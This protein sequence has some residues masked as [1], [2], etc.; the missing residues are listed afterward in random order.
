MEVDDC[1]SQARVEQVVQ[2]SEE[3]QMKMPE[4]CDSVLTR[5]GFGPYAI[6]F[7]DTPDELVIILLD[8]MRE[9]VAEKE[10]ETP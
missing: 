2:V 4:D 5:A 9:Y 6:D 10:G 3:K 7:S 8:T 1:I